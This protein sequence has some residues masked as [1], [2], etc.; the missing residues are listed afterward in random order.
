VNVN[1]RQ[2]FEYVFDISLIL[3]YIS[4]ESDVVYIKYMYIKLIH[5]LFYIYIIYYLFI[6]NF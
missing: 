1:R 5:Q 3:L 6:L 4:T 2:R